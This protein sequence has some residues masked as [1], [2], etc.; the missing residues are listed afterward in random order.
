MPTAPGAPML[1]SKVFITR[2]VDPWPDLF[3]RWWDGEEWIWVN[4]GRPGGQRVISAPGAAMMD[5]KLFVVVQDGALWERHWRAD[6]GAWVW[7]DHG[8]PENR[9][10]RFDPGCAMMNEKLFVVVD[11][12]RLWERHWRRDLN[13]WVWFD[14]GRPNNE[15]IVASPGAAMMDSKLF[16]VTETGHLWERNWRGDL[17]RWVWFDHGLPPGAHAVGAPGAAMMNA[18][19]FV[20]GSNGHLFERFWNGSAWVWVDHGSPPGT[21]V[22]TEPGAAMM[23]AKLFVGAADGR[24]FER[25]WNGTAWVWV[26][27][28]RPP[29]T[30]VATAPGGAMLDS[31]LFVGTANQRMFERFWNGAQ[32]VWVDHGTLLHDNRA[33]LLDNSAAGPKKTLAVIGDGFDEVSLGSYQGWVQHEVMNGV[34]SHDLYRDLKSA[35]N[36]IRIDLIS[37][38]AGVSQRRYDEHGTPSVASDDTI[39]ST[40][41]KN[42]RLGFLYSGSWA[43]CWLEQQSFTAARIAKVL[44]RFA[45]NFDYVLVLLNEG[46]Q[47]GCGGGGQQTVTRGENWTTIVHEFGHG[48]GG[49]ADE[50]S[51]QGLHFT[52]TSF[53]QPN[54]SI[55]GTRPG[56]T[57]ASKVAAGVPLPTT[58]TPS[59]WNDNQNVGAFEG[60]GT[61]ETG[62]FRPVKNC[63]MRSNEPPYC[64]V[65]AEVMRNV[66]GP[67]A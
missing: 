44:A 58:T 8:R 24:L 60:R 46:G 66:L 63:R 67:F 15:R 12:G 28:G 47:G 21:A 64:P 41:L 55:A 32:W 13:A 48:L 43:H 9:P 49:L 56:L 39:R 38:D 45:P 5:E 3:E 30:A 33:T 14:H 17:N 59:G 27:H 11:D 2:T 36:V 65:C 10:I 25:F 51:Q 34:F 23:S 42:T 54:C 35:S 31:K 61:F 16:V 53:A 62:L 19:F 52:G 26:D 57:W 50:Y 6:L 18:K 20:R 7:A 29:G 1:G 4:H 22:A 40:V 37:L